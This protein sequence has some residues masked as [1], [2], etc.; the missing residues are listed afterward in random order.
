MEFMVHSMTDDAFV[1][2]F[3]K[4]ELPAEAFRHREHV[5]LT[6]IY[7]R[8]YGVDGARIR[9][10]EGIRRYALHNGAAQKYHETITIAW[11]RIVQ[12]VMAKLPV[13][14]VSKTC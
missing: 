8:R 3:E 9:I 5:R 10:S 12:D 11:L 1:L 4:C 13:A 2:A 7:L 14:L 6:F